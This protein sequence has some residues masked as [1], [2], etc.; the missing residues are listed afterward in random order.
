MNTAM[1]LWDKQGI[2]KEILEKN[3]EKEP[4]QFCGTGFTIYM[5]EIGDSVRVSTYINW[6]WAF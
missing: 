5:K 1:T 4:K 2:C 6:N 3:L